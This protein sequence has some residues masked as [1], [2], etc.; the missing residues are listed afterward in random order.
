MFAGWLV[1]CCYFGLV[2][3][4]EFNKNPSV[5]VPSRTGTLAWTPKG[6]CDKGLD[7]SWV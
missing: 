5:S 3:F 7:S 4:L 6:L 1:V 2:L